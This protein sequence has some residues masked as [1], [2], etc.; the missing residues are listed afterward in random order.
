MRA[1]GALPFF[2]G[3]AAH[4]VWKPRAAGKATIGPETRQN[5][6]TGSARPPPGP[7]ST[8]SATASCKKR[9]APAMM[10][11]RDDD[12]LRFARDLRVPF[13]NPAEQ[14]IQMSKVR[15][16][17]SSPA[18][19]AP[20]QARKSSAIRSCPAAA[21]HGIGAPGALISASQGRAWIPGT[22]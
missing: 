8:P 13:T 12:Y 15:I 4:D 20:R 7:P 19:R 17:V 18:P 2:R 16:K 1:A 11:A 22:G 3:V 5:R 21:R 14:V 10:Q 9:H 6:R